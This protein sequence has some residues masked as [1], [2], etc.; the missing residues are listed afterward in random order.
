MRPIE[1]TSFD[2]FQKLRARYSPITLG[3]ETAD[4]TSDPAEARYFNFMYKDNDNDVGNVTISLLDGRGMKIFY[5]DKMID[6]IENKANWYALLHEL[7]G[8]AKRNLLTF[9]ARDISKDQLDARDFQMLS[10]IDRKLDQKQ[11]NVAESSMFG[12]RRRSYQTL[13]SVKLIVQHSKPVA[14]DVPGARS[15]SIHNIYL[16]RADGERYKFPYNYL[17]G[18]RAMARHVNEGGTP[19][20]PLGQHILGMI[21]EM[22]DLSKFARMT[23]RHS[24]ED[25]QANEIREQVVNRYQELKGTL[26]SLSNSNAYKTFSENFEP[27]E[28]SET[29]E[30]IA[31]L[32]E[33]FTRQVWD[34]AMEDLLPA[35][36]KAIQGTAMAK[37]KPKLKE[38]NEFETWASNIV[39]NE[40]QSKEIAQKIMDAG[41][42]G[43][44]MDSVYAA[45][46]NYVSA[47]HANDANIDEIA[48]IIMDKT[49]VVEATTQGT[50][51]TVG[52][53]GTSKQP[54]PAQKAAANIAARNV[55]RMTQSAGIK[56]GAGEIGKL[57]QAMVS[58]KPLPR[59]GAQTI[60]G[61]G[62]ELMQNAMQDP[63]KAAQL[64]AMLKRMKQNEDISEEF[65]QWY[66]SNI[67]NEKTIVIQD[68]D[69]EI[70]T[71]NDDIEDIALESIRDLRKLAGI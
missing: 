57:V 23:K 29:D 48:Q 32:R 59:G 7:R 63:R 38:V 15:R 3:D 31:L 24:N 58:G 51:G 19:Y 65:G 16:E 64:S 44:T 45:V 36:N 37:M 71:D 30:N 70:G 27:I 8:F 61:L 5:S 33:R 53:Y 47:Q 14:E 17:T 50:T 26:S 28:L 40:E 56:T 6:R 46:R 43:N 2:L 69:D 62:N 9:D 13:E 21:K 18:A 67:V 25:A 52:T 60:L 54:T 11:V 39:E 1:K 4:S 41:L 35:V 12:T 42:V 55:S 68:E 49:G 34:T 22:R 66:E 20:D 10:K